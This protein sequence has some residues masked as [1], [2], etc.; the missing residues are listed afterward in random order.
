M[1]KRAEKR[2]LEAYP[3]VKIWSPFGPIPVD[4]N[5]VARDKYRQ[6]YEQAEKDAI[7]RACN[8]FC[9]VCNHSPHAT[10]TLLC[11]LACDSYND[12]KKAMGEEK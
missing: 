7:Q 10:P 6:G 12:F 11:R 5:E 8:A 2:A 9:E 1:N 4:Q 3:V